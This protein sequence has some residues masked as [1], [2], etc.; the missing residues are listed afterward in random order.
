MVKCLSAF[1]DFCYLAR[2]NALRTNDIKLLEDALSRFHYHRRIFIQTGVRIDISL[3]RQHALKHYPRSIRLFGSPNGLCSSITESKHIK[4][5]KEPWR[6]SN[7]YHALI[8]MLRTISRLDK[9]AAARRQF[10]QWG[11]MVGSTVSYTAMLLAGRAPQPLTVTTDAQH[12]EDE[13][14]DLGP[15]SGPQVLSSVK[16]AVTL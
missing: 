15:V 9:L 5:V 14:D 16:L 2:R 10:T 4:A 3:P 13:D 1:L 6:R 7:R 8:Q 12:N 11:M